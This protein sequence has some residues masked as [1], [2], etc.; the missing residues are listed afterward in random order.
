VLFLEGGY[1]LGALERSTASMLAALAGDAP[2]AEPPTSGGPG[3][4][5]VARTAR[6]HA[7]LS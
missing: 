2:A 5:A 4:D 3:L 6:A 1:D 7:P